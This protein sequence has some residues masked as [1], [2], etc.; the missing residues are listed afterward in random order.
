MGRPKK[1]ER[2]K[3]LIVV[4]DLFREKGFE[5]TSMSEIAARTKINK[6]SI[7]NEFGNKEKLFLASMDYCSSVICCYIKESLTKKP[8]GLSNIEEFFRKRIRFSIVQRG[9]ECLFFNSIFENNFFNKRIEKR[10]N[11]FI[12]ELNTLMWKCLKSAQ[13]RK[14][15][16][17]SK[18]CKE[19]ASYLTCFTLGLINTGMS[20]INEN[21]LIKLTKTALV[22]VKN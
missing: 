2:E 15:I 4:T 1:Y 9:K 7:Y 17:S 8:L 6:F 19:L 20:K 5:A 12:L 21:E 13:R 3:I 22:V 10:T 11:E 18:D 16:S 14:E